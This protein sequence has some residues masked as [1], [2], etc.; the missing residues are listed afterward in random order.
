MGSVASLPRP[1]GKLLERFKT[2]MSGSYGHAWTPS[3]MPRWPRHTD[4]TSSSLTAA[5]HRCV[6][7]S[8]TII[9]YINNWLLV[10][11]SKQLLLQHL[12]LTIHLLQSLGIMKVLLSPVSEDSIYWGSSSQHSVLCLPATGQSGFYPSSCGQDENISY[13]SCS[14]NPQTVGSYRGHS[15]CPPSGE[16]SH[17]TSATSFF[18]A[19]QSSQGSSN[20]THQSAMLHHNVV[21]LGAPFHPPQSSHNLTMYTSLLGW[22]VHTHLNSTS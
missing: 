20:Q 17:E 9:P 8:T 10:A 5:L 11:G 7:I 22:G 6:S 19:I 21:V 13:N 18:R 2:F 1:I 3:C 14:P 4:P 15:S 16:T 12:N